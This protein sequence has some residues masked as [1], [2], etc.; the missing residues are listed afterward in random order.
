MENSQICSIFG[1]TVPPIYSQ[2]FLDFPIYGK[3]GFSTISV[4]KA[5]DELWGFSPQVK[6]AWEQWQA[7]HPERGGVVILYVAWSSFCPHY[8]H[9]LLL[10][11]N[12]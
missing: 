9:P 1:V 8:P 4:D 7:P 5:V 11:L 6:K 12:P 2:W 10:L 3:R